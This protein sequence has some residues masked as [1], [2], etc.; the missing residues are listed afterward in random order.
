MRKVIIFFIV[1]FIG[2]IAVYANDYKY[3]I[4]GVWEIYAE[5]CKNSIFGDIQVKKVGELHITSGYYEVTVSPS[6]EIVNPFYFK[7]NLKGKVDVIKNEEG[8]IKDNNLLGIM[9]FDDGG[10]KAGMYGNTL[11]TISLSTINSEFSFWV[12]TKKK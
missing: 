11:G 6:E 7:K 3:N 2:A 1:Y 5:G 8:K 12:I 9:S 10:F 4:D